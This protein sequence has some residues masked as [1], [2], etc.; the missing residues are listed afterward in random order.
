MLIQRRFAVKKPTY[1]NPEEATATLKLVHQCPVFTGLEEYELKN[2]L[3]VLGKKLVPKNEL[4]FSVDQEAKFLFLI[5]KGS[6]MLSLKG[7][8]Y[9]TMTPGDIFGEIG[10]IN[11]HVRTGSMRALEP[12]TLIT[13]HG[14]KLFNPEII[15]A[16]VSLKIA[17]ALARRVSYYLRSREQIS[18]QE[19]IENGETDFVEFKSNLRWNP[20]TQRKDRA[21]E[22]A[23]LKTMAA[24][25]NAKGG[26]LLIG[27]SDEKEIIGIGEDRFENVDK[28]LL[29]LTILIKDR[30]STIHMEFIKFE[31]E[32]LQG[33]YVLR[34][35]CEPATVPAYLKEHNEEHFYVR[36]GPS[37][38]RMKTSK[39]YDYVRMRF[40]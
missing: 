17:L 1:M 32:Q 23:I 19:L 20:Q 31:V 28:M 38:S 36:T 34:I 11:E 14:E 40:R 2:L 37:T 18:T 3:P 33:K 27:V 35:D 16:R 12:T 30:I 29:H 7:K 5:E 15:P 9:K 6:C 22:H 26:T 10:I 25:L 8:K 13:I 39:I 24:F 4:I 21:I